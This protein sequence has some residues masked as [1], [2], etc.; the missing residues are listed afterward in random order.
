MTFRKAT[1]ALKTLR[2]YTK[3][4]DAFRSTNFCFEEL[5]KSIF[6]EGLPAYNQISTLGYFKK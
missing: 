6:K 3:R 2:Y 5:E 4:T 1:D